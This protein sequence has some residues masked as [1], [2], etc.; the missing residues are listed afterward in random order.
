MTTTQPE[1]KTTDV[2]APEIAPDGTPEAA[3]QVPRLGGIRISWGTLLTTVPIYVGLIVIWLYFDWQT[4]GKFIGA[5]NLSEMAQEFSYEA[6]LAIGVVFVLLLGEI[7]LSLGFL[8]LLSVAM[9]VTFSALNQ[10]PLPSLS[11]LPYAPSAGWYKGC[12][13]PGF[14][15]RPLS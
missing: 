11:P 10:L 8:T 6:V 2:T 3:I 1:T 5:R 7:D 12:S 15:C 4:A 9:T 14:A 13:L